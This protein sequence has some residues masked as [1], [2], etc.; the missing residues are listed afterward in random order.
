MKR[1][2]T[3]LF[4]LLTSPLL[5][6]LCI[7]QSESNEMSFASIAYIEGSGAQMLFKASTQQVIQLEW[8]D[9]FITWNPINYT[10]AGVPE[11]I[12]HPVFPADVNG[13][14]SCSDATAVGITRRYYRAIPWTPPTNEWPSPI[15]LKLSR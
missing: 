10:M 8:T 4:A 13:N 2:A 15:F 3:I 6:N 9:D 5:A 7:A 12:I 14:A 11:W 1:I